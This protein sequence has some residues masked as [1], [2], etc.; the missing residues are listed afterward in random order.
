MDMTTVDKND[1]LRAAL[2][3]EP[4]ELWS[5]AQKAGWYAAQEHIR[6]ALAAAQ[7]TPDAEVGR[8]IAEIGEFI[9]VHGGHEMRFIPEEY[10][11]PAILCDDCEIANHLK[12]AAA[13]REG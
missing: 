7:P 3:K 10:E 12:L 6:Q 1:A 9:S 11:P 13:A 2:N 4:S 5:N 8:L